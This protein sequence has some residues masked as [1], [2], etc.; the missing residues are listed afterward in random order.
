MQKHQQVY[1][2]C[3]CVQVCLLNYRK[4]GTPFWNEFHLSPV[5]NEQ[6]VVI[7]YVGMSRYTNHVCC[8]SD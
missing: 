2:T 6:G 3:V 4:D 1:V 7:H 8:M 5:R